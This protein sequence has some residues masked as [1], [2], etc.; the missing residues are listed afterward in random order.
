PGDDHAPPPDAAQ[1]GRD[2]RL[3][4]GRS[5]R[6]AS[7]DRTAA[8]GQRLRRAIEP[9]LVKTLITLPSPTETNDFRP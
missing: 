5:T 8:E 1:R 6:A 3:E 9:V 4:G 2:P 7:A